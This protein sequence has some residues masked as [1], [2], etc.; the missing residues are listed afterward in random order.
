MSYGALNVGGKYESLS[1][2]REV[3]L[4]ADFE[5]AQYIT[6]A[7]LMADEFGVP[8]SS[9]PELNA[10]IGRFLAAIQEVSFVDRDLLEIVPHARRTWETEAYSYDPLSRAST[11]SA[12]TLIIT[13]RQEIEGVIQDILA[14]RP[15]LVTEI[16]RGSAEK[17]ELLRS[18]TLSFSKTRNHEGELEYVDL[19]TDEARDLIGRFGPDCA[20]TL[21]NMLKNFAV[22][23]LYRADLSFVSLRR[24]VTALARA[25]GREKRVATYSTL[26]PVDLIKMAKKNLEC[27]P[28]GIHNGYSEAQW[29]RLFADLRDPAMRAANQI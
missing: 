13:I 15:G 6:D 12:N 14:L 9:M 23:I 28:S 24:D 3:I 10:I 7:K 17:K 11:L 5:N 2:T 25:L 21:K 27:V 4:P 20:A 18:E 8:E 19:L 26:N 29:G 1:E 22:N 16:S